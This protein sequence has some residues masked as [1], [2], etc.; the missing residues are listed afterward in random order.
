MQSFYTQTLE[1]VSSLF[2]FIIITNDFFKENRMNKCH[3]MISVIK[4][5]SFFNSVFMVY[6]VFI[7]SWRELFNEISCVRSD[8]GRGSVASLITFV[9]DMARL[10]LN[11]H[12]NEDKFRHNFIDL[13]VPFGCGEDIEEA[14]HF[15]VHPDFWKSKSKS[16]WSRP[17]LV[18]TIKS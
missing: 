16:P 18:A 14:R 12:L 7:M 4:M 13:Q 8:G 2:I 9:Y 5:L 10:Q 3:E 15:L 11:S 6:N 17:Y 1:G